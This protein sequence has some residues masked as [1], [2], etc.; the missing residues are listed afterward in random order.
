MFQIGD[1]YFG[2]LFSKKEDVYKYVGIILLTVQQA[3]MPLMVRSTR[4]RK[5]NDVFITTVNVFIMEI[6]KLVVCS[7]I[8][9]AK[10]K[11]II[12]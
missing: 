1:H 11:S 5:E 2:G 9:I 12:K 8:L 4:Y 6:V 7:A 10:E 3:S